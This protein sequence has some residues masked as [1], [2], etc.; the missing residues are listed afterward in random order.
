M[1]LALKSFAGSV[2]LLRSD[3]LDKSEPAG[4]SSVRITHNIALLD[5]AVLLEQ[6]GDVSFS[7]AGMNAGDE[8]IGA[9]V[10]VGIIGL[11]VGGR[12][13][14]VVVVSSLIEQQWENVLT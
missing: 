10:R 4:I 14:P 9:W 7:E 6:V 11:R 12:A 1:E 5:F 3:H 2:S 8:E 13:A